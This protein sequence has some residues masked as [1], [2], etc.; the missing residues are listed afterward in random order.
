M[1][2]L[3]GWKPDF[4]SDEGEEDLEEVRV[5]VEVDPLV[6]PSSGLVPSYRQ[7][8]L[9]P[10]PPV[11]PSSSSASS[12]VPKPSSMPK[13]AKASSG[14]GPSPQQ[15]LRYLLEQDLLHQQLPRH[16]EQDFLRL[17]MQRLLLLSL[18]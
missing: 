7:P 2:N 4:E 16:P 15:Q 12:S 1:Y 8:P 18:Q 3:P 11:R 13:A 10:A 6:P 17:Q 5:E 14:A 9:P